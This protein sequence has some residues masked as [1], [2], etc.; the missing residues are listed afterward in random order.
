MHCNID[1]WIQKATVAFPACIWEESQIQ[2]KHIDLAPT[3]GLRFN[4]KKKIQ[5]LRQLIKRHQQNLQSNFQTS[6]ILKSK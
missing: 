6:V 4:F 3:A 5:M 2:P 1:K